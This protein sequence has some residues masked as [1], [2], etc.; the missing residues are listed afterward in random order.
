MN[1]TYLETNRM[2]FVQLMACF[3]FFA[4][5]NL[6]V[7]APLIDYAD[8]MDKLFTSTLNYDGGGAS[9]S[10]WFFISSNTAWVPL[11]ITLV[12]SLTFYKKD[13]PIPSLVI[14]LLLVFGLALTVT[15][16]DQISASVLKP[17]FTRLRPSHSEDI[18][19][20][21]HHVNNYKGGR[22]GF[23]SSHAANAFAVFAFLA[24]TF[25]HRVTAFILFAWACLVSYSRIYLGVHYVG[26]IVA[27]GFLGLTVG[28]GVSLL[29]F[30]LYLKISKSHSKLFPATDY[31][32]AVESDPLTVT[33]ICTGVFM[34]FYCVQQLAPFSLYGMMLYH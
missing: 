2:F 12:L 16:A 8:D 31:R 32:H 19:G 33:V 3:L 6:H 15:I 4:V 11:G 30:Y 5:L 9:D 27:G 17:M 28:R 20:L 14:T 7:I 25:R 34:L 10:F 24:P 13:L 1:R 21:L 18:S 29:F 22:Y 26:D 23:V